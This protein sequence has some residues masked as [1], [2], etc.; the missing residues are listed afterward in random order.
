MGKVEWH[1]VRQV[2][3]HLLI[4]E[5]FCLNGGL[6]RGLVETEVTLTDARFEGGLLPPC[7]FMEMRV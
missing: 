4:I 2:E 3:G 1:F 5:K 7:F 6:T